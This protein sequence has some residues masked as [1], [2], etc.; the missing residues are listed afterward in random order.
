MPSLLRCTVTLPYVPTHR[1]HELGQRRGTPRQSESPGN[2]VMDGDGYGYG[3]QPGRVHPSKT[4]SGSDGISAPASDWK[5]PKSTAC[6][7]GKRRSEADVPVQTQK[8]SFPTFLEGDEEERLRQSDWQADGKKRI[9][10]GRRP[11]RL[12]RLPPNLAWTELD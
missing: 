1:H 2:I 4:S 11:L 6:R 5:T 10:Q 12:P 8:T 7:I 3:A 9:Y